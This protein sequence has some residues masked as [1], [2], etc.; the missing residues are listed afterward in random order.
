MGRR[1]LRL[2]RAQLT[3]EGLQSWLGREVDAVLSDGTTR[4]GRVVAVDGSGLTLE[5]SLHGLEWPGSRHRH[6]LDYAQLD[7]LVVAPYS[8]L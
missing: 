2:R 3:P 8:P 1:T 7:E 5:D 4:H 6:R